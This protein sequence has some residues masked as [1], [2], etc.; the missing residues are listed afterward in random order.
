MGQVKSSF[1]LSQ[2]RDNASDLKY[3]A[4]ITETITQEFAHPSKEFVVVLTKRVY[5]GVVTKSVRDQFTEITRKALRRFLN[6]QISERLESALATTQL[7]DAPDPQT[8]SKESVEDTE[9]AKEDRKGAIVTTEEEIESYFAVKS[10]LRDE[11]DLRRITMRD[12]KN[13]CSV[14]LDN[15]KRKPLCKMHFNRKQKY[16]ELFDKGSPGDRVPIGHVDDIYNFDERLVKTLEMYDAQYDIPPKTTGHHEQAQ[17]G[18]VSYT[19]TRVEAIVF[20]G[21]EHRV[22]TWRDSMFTFFDLLRR[23]DQTKFEMMGVTITGKKRPYITP[24]K[25][26]LRTAQKIPGT[27]LYAETNLDSQSIV[28]ICY[29]LNEKMGFTKDDLS[30]IAS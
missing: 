9:A 25:D 27:N 5:P 14:L 16:F 28:R 21:E 12:F 19:G 30:F 22:S 7:S 10:I 4:A 15:S 13:H 26:L 1:N 3:T 24:S 23:Q 11:T 29:R 18:K 17:G 2:I 8:T 20:Q 6:D